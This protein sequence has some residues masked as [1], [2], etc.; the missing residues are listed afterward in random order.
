MHN[1]LDFGPSSG[2][3]ITI[4]PASPD[5]AVTKMVSQAASNRYG[6]IGLRYVDQ[7]PEQIREATTQNPSLRG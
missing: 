5:Y 4:P 3:I 1:L 2:F 6:V 7:R